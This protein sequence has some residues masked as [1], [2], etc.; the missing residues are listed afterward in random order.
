[1]ARTGP[2]GGEEYG[3]LLLLAALLLGIVTMHTLGHPSGGH[4]G[5]PEPAAMRHADAG[6]P[7][8]RTLGT[9]P[10]GADAAPRERDATT[11]RQATTPHNRDATTRPQAAAMPRGRG[12]AAD[13]S[14]AARRDGVVPPEHDAAIRPSAALPRERGTAARQALAPAVDGRGTAAHEAAAASSRS[15]VARDRRGVAARQAGAAAPRPGAAAHQPAPGHE[16]DAAPASGRVADAPSGSGSGMGM[17]MDPLS[18]CLAVLGA[19]T[20]LVLVRAGLL[21]PGGVVDRSRAPGRLLY[22]LRPNPPPPRI[23]L[24][25]LSVL[26]I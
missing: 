6:T 26:R 9:L 21:R 11:G 2:R 10:H 24:S 20:L 19:F 3:R 12:T 13:R 4:G 18:V 1:M 17:G 8:Q 22:T 14:A 25:R 5:G 23:L 16:R 15:G 7:A